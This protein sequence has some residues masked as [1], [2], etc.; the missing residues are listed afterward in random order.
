LKR[1]F[2]FKIMG[3]P[4]RLYSNFIRGIRALPVQIIS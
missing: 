3:A 1:D 4:K 2:R